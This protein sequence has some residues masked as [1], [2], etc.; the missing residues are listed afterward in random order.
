VLNSYQASGNAGH[1][2]NA[3]NNLFNAFRYAE[4]LPLPLPLPMALMGEACLAQSVESLRASAEQGLIAVGSTREAITRDFAQLQGKVDNLT[5]LVEKQTTRLDT[6]L[7]DQ[8]GIFQKAQEDRHQR[9]GDDR[10][11]YGELL[12]I[13]VVDPG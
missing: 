8:Q 6:A 5:Q 7:A 9:R 10:A 3:T 1:L 4:E 12:T 13:F 11:G 2:A